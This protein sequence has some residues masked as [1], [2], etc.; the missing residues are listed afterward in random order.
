M[1]RGRWALLLLLLSFLMLLLLLLVGLN[2]P[3]HEVVGQRLRPAWA[4]HV[5]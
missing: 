2:L 5:T 1:L 3:V 4:S